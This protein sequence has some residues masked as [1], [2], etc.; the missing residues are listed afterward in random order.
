[1]EDNARAIECQARVRSLMR[2]VIAPMCLATL[3]RRGHLGIRAHQ[4]LDMFQHRR[5]A[6]A[7]LRGF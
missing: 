2:R 1:L 7:A 6:L 3:N 5:P 4:I